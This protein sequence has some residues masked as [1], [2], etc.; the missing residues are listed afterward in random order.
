MRVLIADNSHHSLDWL[1]E[2]LASFKQV[3]I[4]GVYSDGPDTLEA[5]RTLKPDLAIVGLKMSGLSGIEVLTEI[6]KENKSL[7]YIILTFLSTDYY[8]QMAIE[9]GADYFFSKVDDTEKISQVI[10]QMS[11]K[12][13]NTTNNMAF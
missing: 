10:A 5:L 13:S 11:Q 1:K 6:R 4:V 7:N 2:L 12:E 8:R 3:E 9:A